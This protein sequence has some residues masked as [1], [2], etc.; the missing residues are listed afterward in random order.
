MVTTLCHESQLSNDTYARSACV[1]R[2]KTTRDSQMTTIHTF[3]TEH[4][5]RDF[6][7]NIPIGSSWDV[8]KSDNEFIVTVYEGGTPC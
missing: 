7:I 5:A 1:M 4:E 8:S 3:T 2:C 6:A